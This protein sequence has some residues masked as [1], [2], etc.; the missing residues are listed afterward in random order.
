M[1]LTH[2]GTLKIRF[3]E[4]FKLM[5]HLFGRNFNKLPLNT[6]SSLIFRVCKRTMPYTN[7]TVP[8]SNE[9]R[10]VQRRLGRGP[11]EHQTRPTNRRR[12]LRRGV[13]RPM[14]RPVRRSGKDA[15]IQRP[16]ETK[17]A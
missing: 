12:K 1:S 2:N 5:S 14:A 7:E 16:R 9:L 15:K 4:S 11:N 10:W 17:R 8:K 13:Q 3:F 6:M